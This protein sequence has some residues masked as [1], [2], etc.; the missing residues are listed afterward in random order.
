MRVLTPLLNVARGALVGAAEIVP[1]V[2]GGTVALIV[3]LYESLIISAGHLVRGVVR[4][5]IDPPRGRGTGRA[6]GHFAQVRWSVVLPAL[7]GMVI[8]VFVGAA[9][10]APLFE[11]HPVVSRAVFFGMIAASVVVPLRMIGGPLKAWEWL[12]LLAAAALTFL[13]TGLP[14]GR[15][16]DPP[17]W[18]VAVAAAFAICALVLPGVS[19][20]FLLLTIGMYQPTIRA[21]ADRDFGYIALFALGAILGLSM[22]V[23]LLERLLQN[24]RRITLVVMAGLMVGSLRALWPWQD[25]SGGHGA[26]EGDWPWLLLLAAGGALIVLVLI[27]VERRLPQ[28]EQAGPKGE[29]ISSAVSSTPAS[30]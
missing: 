4:I 9:L 14:A 7:L 16:D 12:A 10:L 20:S 30:G 25:E 11:A 6:R 19:G 21:V 1:G 18:L 17:F 22:F 8:A 2:S 29:E 3:G 23:G 15:V 13:L 27:A 26:P 5:V 28:P 24:H